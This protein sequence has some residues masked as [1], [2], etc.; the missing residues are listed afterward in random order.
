MYH[1]TPWTTPSLTTSSLTLALALL[2]SPAPCSAATEVS[3][4]I[5]ENKTWT[6]TESPYE[7]VANIVVAEG[8]K[9]TIEPG[10][11]VRFGAELGMLVY[12]QLEAVGSASDPITFTGLEATPGYWGAI[13]VQG[14]GSANLEWCHI[15][16]GGYYAPRMTPWMGSNTVRKS[17]TGDLSLRHCL[18]GDSPGQGI[19]IEGH[20]A[21]QVSLENTE[22]RRNGDAGLRIVGSAGSIVVADGLLAENGRSGAYVSG[23]GFSAVRTTF[24]E[25]GEYGVLQELDATVLL[26][27][28][29]FA[30]NALG[31][32]GINGGTI[33][34]SSSWPAGVA[35]QTTGNI[36]VAE[37]STLTLEPG[38]EVRFGSQ[39]GMLVYGQLDAL[40]TAADAI[41]FTGLE[42]TPGY[43]GAIF[44]QES[45]SAN[46]EWCHIAYGGY[47]VPRSTPWMASNAIRKSGSGDL[48]LTHCRVT[49]SSGRAL[50]IVFHDGQVSLTHTELLRNA[51]E[52][53]SVLD[54]TGAVSL[55][56][57]VIADNAMSGLYVR[58]STV[59]ATRNTF[60]Q[61]AGYGILQEVDA[62]VLLT[63]NLFVDNASGDR[64]I[65]G[66]TIAGSTL[67]QAGVPYEITGNILIPEGANL[68][69]EPGV[70]VRFGAQLGMLVY[71]H[72]EAVGTAADPITF[73]GLEPTPGYWGAIF[74]LE[75]GSANLEWCHISFGGYYVPRSTPWMAS[76]AVRK[77]G[78]GDLI[79]RN[80]T[81]HNN[82]GVGLLISDSLGVHEI[83]RAT[84]TANAVGIQVQDQ[85]EGV[86]LV[87]CRFLSN[88]DFGVRNLGFAEVDARDNWWGDATGPTHE[89]NPDGRGDRVS[90]NVLFE[91]WRTLGSTSR[92]L[93]PRRE[94]ALLAGDSLRFSAAP[95]EDPRMGH[96]W[97][98]GDGRSSFVGAP[99]LVTFQESG[100][101]TIT[102]F[103][104]IDGEL[105][106]MGDSRRMRVLNVE[107]FHPDLRVQRMAVPPSL[108]VGQPTQIPYT[109]RNDG[110]HAFSGPAWRDAIYLSQDPFLDL[111]DVLLGSRSVSGE[112]PPGGDYEGAIE[113]TLPPVE[114]G[115][116]YLILSINDDWQ[117][118]ERH[119]LNNEH[120]EP[121]KTLVPILTA[122]EPLLASFSAGRVAHYYRLSIGSGQNL[123]L[124]ID[125][126]APGLEVYLRHG[127]LPTRGLHDYRSTSQE[128][129]VPTATTGDWY[130]LVY[131][132]DLLTGGDYSLGYSAN[133]LL[134]SQ[135]SPS[136]HASGVRLDLTLI[137]AGF[138]HPI[139]V[140]LVDSA[141]ALHL[142]DTVE[143]DTSSRLTAIFAPNRLAP[144]RY[145]V[146]VARD[147]SSVL[148]DTAIE[149]VADGEPQLE[150]N[151]I[152]PAAVGLNA[153][154]TIHVE[155]ANTGQVSMPA[156]ILVLGP[157]NPGGVNQPW[158]AL[159]KNKVASGLWSAGSPEGFSHS[160][161]F[162]ASG[163]RAGILQP[164]ESLRVPIHFVGVAN[165]DR[166]NPEVQFSLG[167]LRADDQTPAD[168]ASLKSSM[169]PAYVGEDAWNIVWDN[170]VA[171]AGVTWGDYA[172][173]LSR[174][175]V[176][177]ERQGQL[178]QDIALLLALSFRQADAL[179]P[180]PVLASAT[181]ATL[182]APG[183]PLVFQRAYAQ[184]ISRRFEL[185][186]LGR[187]WTHNWQWNL[188]RR[189]SGAIVITDMTGTPR[190]FQPDGRPG[191]PYLAAPGDSGA[192]RP[193]AGDTFTLTEADGVVRGFRSDGQLDYVA[194]PNGNRISCA[195][196]AG[197]LT[198]LSHSSGESLTLSYHSTGLL[199]ELLDAH[200][201][202]TRFA[203]QGEHLVTVT[204]YDDR[205]TSYA[206]KLGQAPA[207][208]HALAEIALPDGTRRFFDYDSRGRLS[209]TYRD[210]N[211]ET[212][213]FDHDTIGRVSLTDALGHATRYFFDH[214]GRVAKIEN[215]LGHAVQ[216]GFDDLG[217][218]ANAVDPAGLSSAFEYDRR[219]NLI[220]S[221]DALRNVTRFT[222]TTAQ[223]RLASL[224]D[225]RGSR[226]IYENDPN[227]NLEAIVYA[228]GSRERWTYDDA[229]N[230]SAWTN[231]RGAAIAYQR[232]AAG[233]ITRKTFADSSEVS[234]EYDTRGNLIAATDSNGTTG[235]IYSDHDDL[236][237]VDYP[238][239]RWLEFTYDDAGRRHSS[240][241]QTGRRLIYRY[242]AAGRLEALIEEPGTEL[243]RYAYDPVGR[244]ETKT[245]GNGVY[246][247]YTYDA[248]GQILSLVNHAPDG[249]VI[250]H[251]DYTYDRQGRRTQMG[252]HYGT[253][254]YG[255]D[256]IGQLTRAILD[257]THP[258]IPDQDLTYEYDA[259]GNRTRTIINGET[260]IYDTNE[261]NQYTK[262]GDRT[263][264]FDADG[265]LIE[266]TGPDG[267]TLY[268]YNDE[269]RL[270]GVLR[271]ADSWS[272]TYDPL[273]NRVAT[274]E[275]GS[276]T[277]YVI[278]PI[279]LGNLVGE[280]DASGALIARYDHGFGLISRLDPVAGHAF[281][282][283]DAIGSTSEMVLASDAPVGSYIYRP[284]GEL[285]HTHGTAIS[286]LHYV[287]EWGG[288]STARNLSSMGA[289]EYAPAYGIFTSTDPIRVVSGLANQYTYC[290][291]NPVQFIDPQGDV[292]VLAT[293]TLGGVAF[294]YVGGMLVV[295][296]VTTLA[297]KFV[298]GTLLVSVPA[299]AV[300]PPFMGN[301][302]INHRNAGEPI[303][304]RDSPDI[305]QGELYCSA[306]DL[307]RLS[308]PSRQVAPS[309]ILIAF[310]PNVKTGPAGVGSANYV[311]A[312]RSLFYRIDFE[313]LETA[314]APAQVV[315]VRDPL[316]EHLDWTTFELTELGFGD[317]LISVPPGLR[318]FETV[319]PITQDDSVIEVHV[320]AGIDL[321]AGEVFATFYTIDP[322]T[323][324]PPPAVVGFLPPEDGT[325]R[326]Q[327]HLAYV[328]RPQP[329]LASDTAIRNVATIQFDFGLRIDTNQIDPLDPAQG[330]DPALEALVTID[331]EPP[332][333]AINPLPAIS[334]PTF[335]V[336]LTGADDASGL[337]SFDIYVREDDGP[338]VLWTTT[339]DQELLYSGQLGRTYAFYSVAT[340]RVGN[341]ESKPAQA[342]TSTTT[343]HILTI[344]P[345]NREH[346]PSASTGHQITVTANLPWTA[347]TSDPWIEVTSGALGIGNGAVVY[348]VESNE[349][350]ARSGT[351]TVSGEGII[352]PF[353]VSQAGLITTNGIPIDWLNTYGLPT[354]G[355]VDHADLDD[356]GRT[357]LEEWIAGTD[358][359][360]PASRFALPPPLITDATLSVTW[361]GVAGRR[362]TLY[363][364]TDPSQGDWSVAFG[365]V[366]AEA[367]L[368][369]SIHSG[370][371]FRRAS[372]LPPRRRDAVTLIEISNR[373]P[374][375]NEQHDAL[376][377][378]SHPN[379][380]PRIGHHSQRK[381]RDRTC[382]HPSGGLGV[383]HR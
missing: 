12:G 37:G 155:Y 193:A 365:P 199:A 231:R 276:L 11:E 43:W 203:Y 168:W 87:A 212:V 364:S 219:G 1:V 375:T 127:S 310:D 130:V 165:L 326:G 301:Y 163:A 135:V 76:N 277:H 182:P 244:L 4:T 109:V 260:A 134:L 164:G 230:A 18:V 357:V 337:Q 242:D 147:A 36:I 114:D 332:V 89:S 50:N 105:D 287:G 95:F 142:P 110:D 15:A 116:R 377:M 120:T 235:F 49:E 288:R 174:N 92:I 237:R 380:P 272:Y 273:G 186:P 200:G 131:G 304:R 14:A 374:I 136:L 125:P 39:L 194:D 52:G 285:L 51:G 280:Y 294:H 215:P 293:I 315:T 115:L 67:W 313:N 81:F 229:G 296:T 238:G 252:T 149:I 353:A 205:V 124:T 311:A 133:P 245:L 177:L 78:F 198:G 156:P 66:G 335:V 263:F 379:S 118:L 17:G 275:N 216:F 32:R 247:Q 265:N 240:L 63:D 210:G 85:T 74:A 101:R 314:T 10:V 213:A 84:F 378:T 343:A 214:A 30:D 139:E 83:V 284:F 197:R 307:P 196:A 59:S 327:G 370:A 331:A 47:Y 376:I 8:A 6:F 144:G 166:S 255:Y 128:L 227:G 297:G 91:P 274:V 248:A 46:F 299:S 321:A 328:V 22:L 24:Q 157:A 183:L 361:N 303:I 145:A 350:A 61:N 382:A 312:E 236:L 308:A 289:R 223:S 97:D 45:G 82:A 318:Y 226:T 65:N 286:G 60:Q 41:M 100:D 351:I 259:L 72:L 70:E 113:V 42:P 141:G 191:R 58:F 23:S 140:A 347:I 267:T 325:G 170:F 279:G 126:S 371:N 162:L 38:V 104:A 367:A 358:P 268:T 334:P 333:S 363:R 329:G 19:A 366:I 298:V 9:L 169:R 167:A 28:N 356:D 34:G 20:E 102:L 295:P 57:S 220:R 171:Q 150:T 239:D 33:T 208:E 222:Y 243:V 342:G 266:E 178:V 316:S 117:V 62:T 7:V 75:S 232:D 13:F 173:M 159:D 291:N 360:D 21:G 106:P 362:Y 254:E 195:Y 246:T 69:V 292:V 111:D 257:S 98:F 340:D 281:Y 251:F 209:S 211:A 320:E 264:Q 368:L 348:T 31:D 249:A 151:L 206:Y 154:A 56:D 187:G 354:D 73:T 90:D 161:Q 103:A 176:H 346:E 224:I 204:A 349:T 323:A 253:W 54:S 44:I 48:T 152:V 122:G 336:S 324:L 16:Y 107:G 94:G 180:V 309:T 175:A 129:V 217:R 262:V 300:L 359:I 306:S 373:D 108:A 26:T 305:A 372:V 383:L 233:R 132:E 283:F 148:L 282:T 160:V 121:I 201:R 369:D 68:T 88:T 181:D 221:T 123:R 40:G 80:S 225:A 189:E 319:V 64:G 71:G 185:G 317:E 207:T 143:L 77:S 29:V 241:D 261:L 234:Y 218:L 137:G 146:R 93:A 269:N 345:E 344:D 188:E 79:V 96:S 258:D 153:H 25:N 5:A 228:D 35:Y 184:P 2:L 192:L 172:A 179:S 112:I 55:L 338:F 202:R 256:D 352:R 271:G 330:T 322:E 158:L 302:P 53:L 250:S 119:R 27:D 86:R 381:R 99:G 3:G 138:L 190:I 339:T 278:D 355:S 290:W 270:V 341:R